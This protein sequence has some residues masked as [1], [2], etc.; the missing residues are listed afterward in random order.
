MY[1]Q[2]T[3]PWSAARNS[4]VDEGL[5]ALETCGGSTTGQGILPGVVQI[6]QA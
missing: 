2:Q 5:S 1:T 4:V 6:G 3:M